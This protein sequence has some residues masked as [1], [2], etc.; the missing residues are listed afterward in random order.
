MPGK[1][2]LP[3]VE[4]PL[5]D[6]FAVYRGETVTVGRFLGDAAALS[7][8]LPADGFVLNLARDR[9]HFQV[10]FAAAILRGACTLL[11]P[12]DT[13]GAQRAV[14]AGC[15]SPRVLHDGA[16]VAEGLVGLDLRQLP[17]AADW[18]GAIPDIDAD[19][20]VSIS[21]TSGSTGS[22]TEIARRWRTHFEGV[23]LNAATYLGRLGGAFGMVATVPPQH[24]YGMEVTM[25]APLRLPVTVSA[26][27]P[28]FPADVAE[29][30]A[31]VPSPRVLVSTPLHLEALLDSTVRFPAVTRVITATA[32]L[33]AGLARRVEERLGAELIDVY[34]CSETGCLA[35]RRLARD[36][37]W[38]A[39]PGFSF[40][41]GQDG[42]TRVSAAHLPEP[43]ALQ[44]RLRLDADGIL[45]LEG[46]AS[47]LVN[48]GGKRGSLAN[49]TAL[50]KSA[51]GVMDGAVF[52]PRD[53]RGG[54]LAGVYAGSAEPGDVRAFLREHLDPVLVPRPLVRVASLPR[55]ETG[56]LP[57][58][59]LERLLTEHVA[60][61][62][63]H[64]TA[65][66][67]R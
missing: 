9:Y 8:I 56:K 45:H 66:H 57:L 67:D 62:V 24:M 36:E 32:P 28:L 2:T 17:P 60:N 46:R 64:R 19:T 48:V 25:M 5:D 12:N 38:T 26:T 16:D 52:Q 61:T 43:V 7:E 31:T 54:R 6:P 39:I 59:A 35:T 34:G 10:A 18:S 44:D 20:V 13:I 53:R 14:S 51:P 29:A 37:A 33:D 41:T 1:L 4:R 55:N 22:A 40:D 30:L 27:R 23:A 63:R 21:F 50:L 42:V 3:L 11:P 49:L 58:D 15:G 47:D 65:A